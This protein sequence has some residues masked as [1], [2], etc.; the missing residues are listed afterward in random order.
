M[1]EE[2]PFILLN[3]KIKAEIKTFYIFYKVLRSLYSMLRS[4]S[5]PCFVYNANLQ[6][7][8]LGKVKL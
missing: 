4:Y 6:K 5:K 1:K 8:D 2:P 7:G 3:V